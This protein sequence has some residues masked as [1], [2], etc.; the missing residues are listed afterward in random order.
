MGLVYS[1]MKML[2]EAK[3]S[4]TN[5][6][7]T[8]MIG[9]QKINLSKRE[10]SKLEKFIDVEIKNGTINFDNR[11][12]ADSLL[13]EYLDIKKLNIVD[14]SDYEGANISLDLNY[15]IKK[16]F[17]NKYDVLIDGG[18]IEHIFNF[19]VA[20][21][22]YMNLIK[23]NGEIFIFT[24][25]NNHCG[26]GFYQFSPELFYRVFN[27]SNGF[28]IKSVIL[29]EHP[30]PGAELSEKHICY[31]VNDP[32]TIG[33]R[34]LIVNKSPLGILVNA[35][36]TKEVKI[37]EMQPLQSDYKNTWVKN[38]KIKKEKMNSIF[39]TIIKLL[40]KRL[41]NKLR[42]IKQLYNSSLKNDKAFFKRL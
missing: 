24:N 10:N 11:S 15:P 38:K 40:P 2:L 7:N 39:N 21:K 8:V 16:I 37:F 26:H 20:I 33:R 36:K 4:G 13:K 27:K 42:G 25:A 1:R 29:L 31:K 3:K 32:E 14:Y 22:N 5:F 28:K 18:S 12:Y 6:S 23:V 41:M 9:R 34:A 17:Y 35:I 19:P 30:Y